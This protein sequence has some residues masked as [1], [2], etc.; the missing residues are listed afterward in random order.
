VLA[1]YSES[2]TKLRPKALA[3]MRKCLREHGK[4]AGDATTYPEL[5]QKVGDRTILSQCET[6]TQ[7]G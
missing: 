7:G 6:A 4:T 3:A 5:A 1:G 2:H